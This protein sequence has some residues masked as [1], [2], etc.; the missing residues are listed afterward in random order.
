MAKLLEKPLD[1]IWGTNTQISSY[2]SAGAYHSNFWQVFKTYL[3][4]HFKWQSLV[5]KI[6]W[7]YRRWERK[8]EIW[9]TEKS[10]KCGRLGLSFYAQIEIFSRQTNFILNIFRFSWNSSWLLSHC[11]RGCP[12]R[13][14]GVS[15]NQ[16]KDLFKMRIFI[17]QTFKKLLGDF[18]VLKLLSRGWYNPHK[19]VIFGVI[20]QNIWKA[21][22]W[23][24]SGLK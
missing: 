9:K 14:C 10:E 21:P 18:F 8:S 6:A 24:S 11:I 12:S 15:V 3:N 13:S 4:S 5:V 23:Q 2:R 17:N 16:A 7:Y 19:Y 22:N 1:L 20:A